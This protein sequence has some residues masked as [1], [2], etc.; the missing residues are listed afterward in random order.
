MRIAVVGAGAIGGFLGARL[1]LAGEEVTFV[2][3]GRNFEAIARDGMRLIEES[4]LERIARPGAAP[5]AAAAGAHDLVLLAVKSHQV[6]ALAPEL[7]ALFGPQTPLVTLQNGVPWWFFHKLEG[8]YEGRLV[9]S[10]D[11]N[12]SIGEHIENRR[13]IGAV[14]YPAAELV[15]PGLVKV[16]EGDRFILGE[17]DNARSERAKLV[18]ETFARAGFKASVSTDIRSDI[19]LKLWGNLVFNPVSALSHATLEEICDFPPTRAL[20]ATMMEE[21][22]VVAERLG[23]R[24]RVSIERRIAGAAAVGAHKT[25]ML[26]DVEAGRALELEAL[27]GAVVELARLTD[28][29]TPA[30]DAVYACAALL[31]RTLGT[32]HGRLRIE[33]DAA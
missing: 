20:A 26:Q 24:V 16:I 13:V 14:V 23:V 19:W 11:P 4:G 8:P 30:I 2:A 32:K 5:S 7:P 12:G 21:S 29:P 25:S 17:P 6:A 18:A 33:G 22:K 27:T 9:R 31:A 3:R 1:S 10:V 28:A 15:E